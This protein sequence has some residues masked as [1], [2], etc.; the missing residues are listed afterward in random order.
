ML[1]IPREGLPW[2]VLANFSAAESRPPKSMFLICEAV[3]K[4]ES[5]FSV[6]DSVMEVYVTIRNA[7]LEEGS[8]L[9]GISWSG[10]LETTLKTA[11]GPVSCARFKRSS[12]ANAVALL[13]DAAR[14]TM[15]ADERSPSSAV[16]VP[17]PKGYIGSCPLGSGGLKSKRLSR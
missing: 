15:M 9:C 7:R 16:Q 4:E 10:I 1:L 5:Q 8:L 11:K 3:G 14:M 12:D 6:D 17:E 2:R 13:P